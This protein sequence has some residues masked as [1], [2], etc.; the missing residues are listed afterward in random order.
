MAIEEILRFKPERPIYLNKSNTGLKTDIEVE[1]K[2][3]ELRALGW[4]CACAPD[5]E[6]I[7]LH[8]SFN[9]ETM[10][11]AFKKDAKDIGVDIK[12]PEKIIDTD[13]EEIFQK[14][15]K[16]ALEVPDAE[17]KSTYED[18]KGKIHKK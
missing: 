14:N 16:K 15:D 13:F 10:L 6:P 5:K 17:E 11:Q 9:D 4:L 8:M 12:N 18:V 7:P 2:V 3:E 1:L